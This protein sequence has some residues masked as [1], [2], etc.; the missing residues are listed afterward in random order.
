MYLRAHPTNANDPVL[1]SNGPTQTEILAE[2]REY[3]GV[4][5]DV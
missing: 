5:F 3:V 4:M 2:V 1:G